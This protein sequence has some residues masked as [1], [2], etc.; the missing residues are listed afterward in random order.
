MFFSNQNNILKEF[1]F[2]FE[3]RLVVPAYIIH[4]ENEG[5]EKWNLKSEREA[6]QIDNDMHA[7]RNEY[8]T[9]PYPLCDHDDNNNHGTYIIIPTVSPPQFRHLSPPTKLF[10]MSNIYYIMMLE[11]YVIFIALFVLCYIFLKYYTM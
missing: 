6:W 9:N 11:L 4:Y 5:N 3:S 8:T 7:Q 2:L 1:G 10:L